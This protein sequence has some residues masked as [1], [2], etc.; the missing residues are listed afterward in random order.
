M[1]RFKAY[2]KIKYKLKK[3]RLKKKIK[4]FLFQHLLTPMRKYAQT[5]IN[6]PTL[7]QF[8]DFRRFRLILQKL[9]KYRLSKK[10]NRLR[11]IKFGTDWSSY[12][13]CGLFGLEFSKELIQKLSPLTINRRLKFLLKKTGV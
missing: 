13:A 8:H 11:P 5:A 1:K 12:L 10:R 7:L 3:R 6:D 4:A 9:L 2:L